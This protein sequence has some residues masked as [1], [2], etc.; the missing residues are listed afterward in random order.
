MA[1]SSARA[2]RKARARG[3][4]GRSRQSWLG[5]ALPFLPAAL[6]LERLHDFAR[7]VALVV[8]GEN[9]LGAQLTGRFQHA[10]R[11]H[12]LTL[13]EEV[14]QQALISD[15]KLVGAVGDDEGD[16]LAGQF[17]QGVGLDEAADAKA[18]GGLHGFLGDFRRA[19]EEYDVVS[20]R[21]E[22]NRGGGGNDRERDGDQREAAAS[23]GP[24]AP[25]RPRSRA[26]ASQ[27]TTAFAPGPSALRASA[28]A[29][30]AFSA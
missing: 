14:R 20:E 19:V 8:L 27:L 6:R 22:R 16:A 11:D 5:D 13:A 10:L 23:A 21:I 30:L 24:L 1:R 17:D 26:G 12:A 28:S 4:N 2:R 25:P 7:H 29:A 9:G 3:R 18:R 15:R